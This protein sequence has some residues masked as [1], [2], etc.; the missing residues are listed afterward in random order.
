MSDYGVVGVNVG[1]VGRWT[2]FIL[3]IVV[4]LFVATD[5]IPAT[6]AH[7]SSFFVMLIL[8]FIALIVVFTAVHAILG[9]SLAG[10]SAW[11]G[12]II[13][14]VPIMFLLIA[15]EIDSKFQ[16]G[17]WLN[18]PELNHPFRIALL[19]YIGFSFFFQWRD[20]YGGC[21]A[22]A[23]PNFILKKNYGSYCIPLLPLDITEKFIVD[24]LGKR[25]S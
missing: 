21:E 13:F 3:G 17:H 19:L 9:D 10:R 20:K 23:I 1:S 6:H 5:F 2:R 8:S 7:G 4:I 11:W 16:P 24:K 15:P 25:D 14:V 18:Y 22:V 12:T